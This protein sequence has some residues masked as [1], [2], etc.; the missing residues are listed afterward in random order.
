MLFLPV[1]DQYIRLGDLLFVIVSLFCP[2]FCYVST[3]FEVHKHMDPNSDGV[4]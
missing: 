2:A 1:S 3:A 4:Q